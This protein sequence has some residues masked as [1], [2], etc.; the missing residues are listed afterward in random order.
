MPQIDD[1][2]SM[3]PE[4]RQTE[5]AKILAE[6]VLRWH[7]RIGRCIG[8]S[9]NQTDAEPSDAAASPHSP[10]MSEPAGPPECRDDWARR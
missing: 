7:R 2:S 6:G 10:A 5:I 4:E 8:D 3:T 9:P 1:A